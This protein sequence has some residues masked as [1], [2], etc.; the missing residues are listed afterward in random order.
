MQSDNY[1]VRLSVCVLLTNPIRILLRCSTPNTVYHVT[2]KDSGGNDKFASYNGLAVRKWI[3]SEPLTGGQSCGSA[4]YCCALCRRI[5]VL[6]RG[7][8]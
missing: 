8:N 6:R 2:N 4:E 7:E 1:R 5:T 3:N